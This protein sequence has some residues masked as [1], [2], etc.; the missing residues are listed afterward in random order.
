MSNALNGKSNNLEEFEQIDNKDYTQYDN[1]TVE[2]LIEIDDLISKFKLNTKIIENNSLS[3]ISN[4]S[5]LEINLPLNKLV[6]TNLN[7]IVQTNTKNIGQPINY[8]ISKNFKDISCIYLICIGF[9]NEIKTNYNLTNN[10]PSN[11]IVCKYGLTKNLH[12]R[13]NEHNRDYGKKNNTTLYLNY[14]KEISKEK[15]YLAENIL[16]E[17]FIRLEYQFN[18]FVGKNELIL[19]PVDE[20]DSLKYE[21]EKIK[22]YLSRDEYIRI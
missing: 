18:D 1:N 11:Y 4:I 21:Y 9:I 15:L 2:Q 16:K 13:L 3:D 7:S 22:N 10:Y 17:T 19:I 6:T 20:L 14:Y 12:R 5:T 8:S